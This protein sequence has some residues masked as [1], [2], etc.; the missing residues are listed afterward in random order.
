MIGNVAT[1]I[2]SVLAAAVTLAPATVIAGN[3]P[4]PTPP[5]SGF[6]AP[7]RR[8][9]EFSFAMFVTLEL[10]VDPGEFTCS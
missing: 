1:A 7:E 8:L 9:A 3:T 6:A 5:D 2:V 4:P 10:E